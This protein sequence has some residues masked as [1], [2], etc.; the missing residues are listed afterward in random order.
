[1]DAQIKL[2]TGS[3]KQNNIDSLKNV[4]IATQYY[5]TQ[6]RKIITMMS[7]HSVKLYQLNNVQWVFDYPSK[8]IVAEAFVA[9]ADTMID[10]ITG[11]Y[12]P[13]LKYTLQFSTKDFPGS[14]MISYISQERAI[15]D[16]RIPEVTD[17]GSWWES[18][19]DDHIMWLCD[20]L[21]EYIEI[22][23]QTI[24]FSIN[25]SK[26]YKVKKHELAA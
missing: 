14:K 20:T 16:L 24:Y 7:I 12:D 10:K 23:D 6:I 22:D 18:E 26:N 4:I 8:K 3:I 9:G 13:D 17:S 19:E 11:G 5:N 21:D 25:I 1:M 2:V 15:Q